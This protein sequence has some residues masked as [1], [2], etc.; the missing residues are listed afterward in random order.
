MKDH[1]FEDL[2][3]EL[4][5]TS[6]NLEQGFLELFVAPLLATFCGAL[7]AYWFSQWQRKQEDS[8][9]K[10][11]SLARELA[12]SVTTLDAACGHYWSVCREDVDDRDEEQRATAIKTQFTHTNRLAKEF[13]KLIPSDGTQSR[14]HTAL[15]RFCENGFDI[16]TGDDFESEVR[17]ASHD[18]IIALSDLA[19]ELRIQL[20][21]FF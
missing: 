21:L 4:K 9:S 20:T 1:Q 12:L 2:L 5:N 7:F 6:Q 19:S 8:K 3:R 16:A 11:S 13:R 18:K 14:V 10:I 17:A 15:T